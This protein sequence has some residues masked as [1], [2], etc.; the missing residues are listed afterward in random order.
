MIIIIFFYKYIL[1]IFK[2][3]FNLLQF[4][5]VRYLFLQLVLK[6]YRVTFIMVVGRV[7]KI[8]FLIFFFSFSFKVQDWVLS[9]MMQRKYFCCLVGMRSLFL[10]RVLLSRDW[11]IYFSGFLWW[12]VRQGWVRGE[13]V[14]REEGMLVRR[15]NMKQCLL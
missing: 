10:R 14:E 6:R 2:F 9:I 15:Q 4:G 7:R 13:G 8:I 12:E 1:F 3:F 5:I 11:I